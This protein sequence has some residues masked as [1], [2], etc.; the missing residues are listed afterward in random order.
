MK[1][2]KGERLIT[3]GTNGTRTRC[4]NVLS[5]VLRGK[6]SPDNPA[7]EVLDAVLNPPPEPTSVMPPVVVG[8]GPLD[9]ADGSRDGDGVGDGEGNSSVPVPQPTTVLLLVSG[10]L[11][12]WGFRKKFKN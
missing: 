5:E 6:T 10:L 1:V 7:P 8:G 2:S 3:D 11:G 9:P 12:L 4:A